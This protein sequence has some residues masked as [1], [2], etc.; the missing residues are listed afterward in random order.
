MGRHGA[1]VH[2]PT[3]LKE[4]IVSDTYTLIAVISHSMMI[5]ESK[6]IHNITKTI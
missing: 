3:L 5:E 4:V 6:V 2:Q 1:V